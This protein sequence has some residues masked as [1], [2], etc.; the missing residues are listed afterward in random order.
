M[1]KLIPIVA[2]AFIFVGCDNGDGDIDLEEGAEETE[3]MLEDAG[4]AIKDGA[5]TA[6]EKVEEAVE[7]TKE[8]LEEAGDEVDDKV[9]VDVE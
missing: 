1:K 7:D 6:G 2:A 5:E 3:E 9:D 4:D 8:G